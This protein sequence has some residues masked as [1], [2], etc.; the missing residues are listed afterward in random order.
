[1][2]TVPFETNSAGDDK[3]GDELKTHNLKRQMIRNRWVT[4]FSVEVTLAADQAMKGDIENK[5]IQE[6]RLI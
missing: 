4:T 1:M 3:G 6:C 2:A 5:K